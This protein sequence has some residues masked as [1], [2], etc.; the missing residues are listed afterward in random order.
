VKAHAKIT[1]WIKA[2]VIQVSAW[3]DAPGNRDQ[4]LDGKL[5]FRGCD[6]LKGIF[7]RQRVGLVRAESPHGGRELWI[8]VGIG[9]VPLAIIRHVF[10]KLYALGILKRAR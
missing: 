1:L 3:D 6:S 10:P 4:L 9:F 7:G 5:H 8:V 2:R